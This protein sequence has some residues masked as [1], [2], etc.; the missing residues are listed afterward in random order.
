[1]YVNMAFIFVLSCR[2]MIENV[3]L[4]VKKTPARK[5]AGVPVPINW[6]MIFI[7]SE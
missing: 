3:I 7:S 2:E 6:K 1:M 5:R 4:A